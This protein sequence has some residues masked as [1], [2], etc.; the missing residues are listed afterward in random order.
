MSDQPSSNDPVERLEVMANEAQPSP[1]PAFA[2]RLET[3]LRLMM[4]ERSAPAR[5][6]WWQPAMA[7]ASVALVVIIGWL[8]LASSNGEPV[9]VNAAS[10]TELILPDGD[11]IVGTVGAELPDGTRISVGADGSAIIG[12]V[13]LDAG[14]EALVLDGRVVVI[15]PPPRGLPPAT[16]AVPSSDRPSSSLST[17]SSSGPSDS[18]TSTDASRAS[19]PAS[20][21]PP[22][23]RPPSTDSG[24]STTETTADRSSTTSTTSTSRSSTSATT[25]IGELVI[26]LEVT[27]DGPSRWSLVWTV[28]GDRPGIAGWDVEVVDGD[29]VRVI[30]TLRGASVRSVSVERPDIEV[31]YRVV[32]RNADG[33][34]VATSGTVA[35]PPS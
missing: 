12:G 30:A 23:S 21:G 9:V 11:S 8:A 29:R 17:T 27:E 2:N 28:T 34:A 6:P 33:A 19:S 16:T 31:S 4:A 1:D 25:T 3:D 32:A 5:R 24:P 15:E 13:V 14:S 7:L 26:D 35:A 22:T 20:P 18:P 10:D